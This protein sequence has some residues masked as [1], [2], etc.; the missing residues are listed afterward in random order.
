MR[1]MCLEHASFFCWMFLSVFYRDSKIVLC[2]QSWQSKENH[3]RIHIYMRAHA[4]SHAHLPAHLNACRCTCVW[5][6]S[7]DL[8]ECFVRQPVTAKQIF[9][10]VLHYFWCCWVCLCRNESLPNK[11]DA[12]EVM[13]EAACRMSSLKSAR[14]DE[15]AP[16][17]YLLKGVVPVSKILQT[18]GWGREGTRPLRNSLQGNRAFEKGFFTERWGAE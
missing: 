18:E 16:G 10:A 13:S 5:L 17:E 3:T 15:P 11:I 1:Q 6:N 14:E 9:E 4:H 2:N 8:L 7:H 12:L